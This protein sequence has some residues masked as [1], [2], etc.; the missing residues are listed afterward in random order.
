MENQLR[1]KDVHYSERDDDDAA[2]YAQVN[3]EPQTRRPSATPG[4]YAF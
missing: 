4:V 2:T 1:E 3:A